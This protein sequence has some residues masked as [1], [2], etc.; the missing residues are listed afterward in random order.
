VRLTGLH[1]LLTY[2]CTL[3]CDHCFVW[4]S[5]RRTATFTIE[6]VENV[7]RQ[8]AELG[9]IEWIYFEGGEPFLYHALLRRAVRSAAALGFRVGVVSNA[10]WATTEPDAREWL[11]DLAGLVQ[12]LELSC[13]G[14]HGDVE[15]E[16]NVAHAR[17]AAAA[18]GIPSATIRIESPGPSGT[19]PTVGRLVPGGSPL[20]YRGRAAE[21]L[22]P[23]AARHPATDFGECPYEDLREPGRVHVDPLGHVHLCQGLSLGNVYERPLA[24]IVREYDP[25]AHP[26]AGLLLAAGPAGLARRAGLDPEAR[27]ADACHVC[28]TARKA[29]RPGHPDVLV[30]D[31]L[32][33]RA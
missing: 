14:Y 18:L 26:I 32:T 19:P 20:M 17:A 25:D 3:E 5:P 10:Y 24:A 9:T 21:T 16:R 23:E 13:D 11:G 27:W 31:L 7:L 12:S 29:M 6:R 4:S 28:Y 30:P 33:M 2:G 15:Q 1:F 8:A 22:A